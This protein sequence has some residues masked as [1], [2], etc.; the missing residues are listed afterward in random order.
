MQQCIIYLNPIV[1]QSHRVDYTQKV[2]YSIASFLYVTCC[3][4]KMKA[5]SNTLTNYC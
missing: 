3:E 4:I 5:H 1:S 2:N